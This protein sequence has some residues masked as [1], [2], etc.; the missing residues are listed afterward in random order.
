MSTSGK[1]QTRIPEKGNET[2]AIERSRKT[3]VLKMN[4]TIITL[5]WLRESRDR[6][7]RHC[8]DLIIKYHQN[9]NNEIIDENWG[10]N[11]IFHLKYFLS[12]SPNRYQYSLSYMEISA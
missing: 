4:M 2:R 9:A 6:E 11:F 8:R 5:R 3:G 7:S 12:A 10:T 1:R